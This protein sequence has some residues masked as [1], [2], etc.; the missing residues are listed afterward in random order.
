MIACGCGCMALPAMASDYVYTESVTVDDNTISLSWDCGTTLTNNDTSTS[1]WD[2]GTDAISLTGDFQLRVTWENSSDP[3]YSDAVVEFY[4]S[5]PYYWDWTLG[6]SSGWGDLMTN[7][8][9]TTFV[10]TEDGTE[11]DI[12]IPGTSNSEFQGLYELV[13][14]RSGTTLLVQVSLV[15]TADDYNDQVAVYT[16]TTT[17]FTTDDLTFVITGNPYFLSDIIYYEA[18]ECDST[19]IVDTSVDAEVVA[20]EYY[21]ISGAK[22]SEPAKGVNIVKETLSNGTIVTS[23]IIVK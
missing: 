7:A 4:D 19:A 11:T 22:V 21:T 23:K 5:T 13:A 10:Y 1:W 16:V 14:V 20:T 2:G 18:G 8:T 3:N 12:V 6:E 17:G 15:R 9:A